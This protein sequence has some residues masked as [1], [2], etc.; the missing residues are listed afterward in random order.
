MSGL[1]DVMPYDIAKYSKLGTDMT[2]NINTNIIDF[3]DTI[4]MYVIN[5]D[6]IYV[7]IVFSLIMLFYLITFI[8]NLI[9]KI[10]DAEI[11]NNN[12]N[13]NEGVKSK[14]I[15]RNLDNINDK[16]I[17]T[18]LYFQSIMEIFAKNGDIISKIV[19][20]Q[21]Y[22]VLLRVVMKNPLGMKRSKYNV[23]GNNVG[24]TRNKTFNTRDMYMVIKLK[25]ND[26][27]FMDGNIK[28]NM[29]NTIVRCMNH[30]NAISKEEYKTSDFI[31][32][33]IGTKSH[34]DIANNLA[35]NTSVSAPKTVPRNEFYEGLINNNYELYNFK[36]VYVVVDGPENK[37][38]YVGYI[39]M[40]P[41][42]E[43]YDIFMDVY[44]TTL[45]ESTYYAIDDENYESWKN[46]S[47]NDMRF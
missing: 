25:Y 27:E 33:A 26:Y 47:I 38:Y 29:A 24:N 20:H 42:H 43:I 16:N 8:F 13:D 12:E 39:L 5:F 11:A 10:N 6:L 18:G 17:P 37:K 1:L 36:D 32:V 7:L 28:F 2:D 22:W 34:N 19:P 44:N 30:L 45:F 46:V 21:D 23:H 3:M 15:D 4:K 41:I 31:V 35:N 40:L 9:D 14:K